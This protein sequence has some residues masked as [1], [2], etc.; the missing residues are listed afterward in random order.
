MN[1]VW[2]KE[3][4]VNC[5]WLCVQEA[6]ITTS[7]ECLAPH[8]CQFYILSILKIISNTA[9]FSKELSLILEIFPSSRNIRLLEHIVTSVTH[10]LF[11]KTTAIIPEVWVKETRGRRKHQNKM[12]WDTIV[13]K[14]LCTTSSFAKVAKLK[15]NC[16]FT[17]IYY[18]CT[19][20]NST[21]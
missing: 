2:H 8:Y 6:I 15:K 5:W 19:E 10:L 20:L 16:N 14:Q 1:K 13:V 17:W 12:Q 3:W 9:N 21:N 4:T 18:L 7:C 11:Y